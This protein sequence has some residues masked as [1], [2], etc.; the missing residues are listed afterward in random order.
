[1]ARRK[2]HTRDQL[3][4]M[5][6]DA[7]E[8]I[9]TEQGI[10][11]LTARQIARD[12]GYTVG[13]LYNLF[14]N[15]NDLILHLNLKTM[16]RMEEAFLQ[17][18]ASNKDKEPWQQVNAL[19]SSYID[20]ALSNAACWRLLFEAR[21]SEKVLPDW[22]QHKISALFALVEQTFLLVLQQELEQARNATKILWAGLYGVCLLTLND[23]VNNVLHSDPHQLAKSL[24]NN[25]LL[26]LQAK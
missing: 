21:V 24:V 5:S 20:F 22:Y 7:A 9:A 12:I 14:E 3:K 17:T 10:A 2:D 15:F 4:V 25:Y 23:K 26:G 8:K 16:S 13:T 18:I 19:T 1:M 11:A 6:L